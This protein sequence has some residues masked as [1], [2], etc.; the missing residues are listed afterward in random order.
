M[1]PPGANTRP[2]PLQAGRSAARNSCQKHCDGVTGKPLAAYSVARASS[3]DHDWVP[4]HWLLLK[5]KARS[6]IATVAA[7]VSADPG[8]RN[9]M[10]PL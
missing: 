5:A 3:A 9:G 4:P 1:R 8:P 10:A 7:A 6:Q 2:K